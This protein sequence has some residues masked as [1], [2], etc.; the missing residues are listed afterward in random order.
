MEFVSNQGRVR[1]FPLFLAGKRATNGFDL[2]LQRRTARPF[3]VHTVSEGSKHREASRSES[4]IQH[5]AVERGYDADRTIQKRTQ[6]IRNDAIDFEK[7]GRENGRV[8]GRYRRNQASKRV[9]I[10]SERIGCECVDG[11]RSSRLFVGIERKL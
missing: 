1:A 6:L 5:A 3:L 4:S 11:G 10:E 7:E 2:F 8:F 9:K